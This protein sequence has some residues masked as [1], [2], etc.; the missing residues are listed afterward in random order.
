MPMTTGKSFFSLLPLA[1]FFAA[2]A[3][4]QECAVED[5]V[6]EM[7]D[8]AGGQL[9][10]ERREH[11]TAY[12]DVDIAVTAGDVPQRF[13]F[14]LTASNGYG[15]FYAIPDDESV[16][17]DGLIV[18]FFQRR[19]DRLVP[20]EHDMPASGEPAPDAVFMPGLGSALW[21][22]TNGSAD[23]VAIPTQIWYRA[24]CR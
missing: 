5:A 20:S 18:F 24:G 14:R 3:H 23:P 22:G 7:A 19:G 17:E 21:Y 15:N 16:S 8:D 6:Y 4:A 11:S 10:F 2:P 1:L 12:S 13:G 9:V